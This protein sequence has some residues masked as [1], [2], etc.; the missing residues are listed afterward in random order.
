[1]KTPGR[2]RCE[3]TENFNTADR[4]NRYHPGGSARA[5]GVYWF[6]RGAR[7]MNSAIGGRPRRRVGGGRVGESSTAATAAA[8]SVP[9]DDDYTIHRVPMVAALSAAGF[10]HSFRLSSLRRAYL[11]I[12]IYMTIL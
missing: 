5:G 2:K 7:V 4:R 3:T 9:F 8:M 1:M 6:R 11:Y 12:Y 10:R